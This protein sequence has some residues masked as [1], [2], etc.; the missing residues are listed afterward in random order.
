MG[1]SQEC[2]VDGFLILFSLLT[3]NDVELLELAQVVARIV[4]VPPAD[5]VGVSRLLAAG[6]ATWQGGK[7][8]G[9]AFRLQKQ[10]KL[11]SALVLEDRG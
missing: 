8:V 1:N 2:G 9:A 10:G 11:V 3:K 6:T 4:G 7:P 5:S